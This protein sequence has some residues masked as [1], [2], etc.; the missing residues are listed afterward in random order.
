MFESE[1]T[2]NTAFDNAPLSSAFNRAWCDWLVFWQA[3]PRT[4]SAQVQIAQ[5]GEHVSQISKRLWRSTYSAVGDA[6]GKQAKATLLAFV[7]L[8][9]EQLLFEEWAGQ[10]DWQQQPMET[11]LLGTRSAGDTI[12]VAI[13]RLLDVRDPAT[14][15]L[16]NVYLLCLVLGFQGRLRS[17]KG[18]ALHEKWRRS[19]FWFSRQRAASLNDIKRQLERTSAIAPQLLPARRSLPDGY[20]LGLIL[21]LGFLILLAISQLF[22]LSIQSRATSSI[23]QEPGSSVM[24]HKH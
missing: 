18:K 4:T 22:W 9:D 2:S 24:E 11:R 17:G 20:R 21:A 15:D 16:A 19:L 10:N 7:G 3:L 14:R 12:P 23:D 6:Q 5:V 13:K 1:W 8:I